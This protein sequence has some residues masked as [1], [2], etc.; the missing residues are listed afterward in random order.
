M[1]K[2]PHDPAVTSRHGVCS[3][4]G[5]RALCG[6]QRA[7]SWGARALIGGTR[8]LAGSPFFRYDRC[9]GY[10]GRQE[11]DAGLLETPGTTGATGTTGDR[12][13][14]LASSKNWVRQ[15]RPVRRARASIACKRTEC[16]AD[17]M[18]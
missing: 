1:L 6:A 4:R 16:Y 17:Y 7:T 5:A 12:N 2:R 18:Q 13:L 14:M 3:Y 8:H 11:P 9:D 15:V 10:D